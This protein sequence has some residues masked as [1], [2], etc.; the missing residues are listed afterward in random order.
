LLDPKWNVPTSLLWFERWPESPFKERIRGVR[1]DLLQRPGILHFTG[2]SKPWHG[3]FTHPAGARWDRC[4]EEA[5]WPAPPKNQAV[6][7]LS[8]WLEAQR[9][10][11]QEIAS[12]VPA[13]ASLVLVG[14]SCRLPVSVQGRRALPFLEQGGVYRGNPRDDATAIDELDRMRRDGSRFI[15]FDR[16][17]F[18]W[19]DHYRGFS[20]HL[21][22]SHSCVRESDRLVIFE[23][24]G[25]HG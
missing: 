22:S 2:P 17:A 9:R 12:V 24:R 20:Q 6:D 16:S 10:D 21:R 19:L 15:V 23:L 5:G 8:V 14:E 25:A 3:H 13:D 1:D 11:D 7:D 18:W 4:R